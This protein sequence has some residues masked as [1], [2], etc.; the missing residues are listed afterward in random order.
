MSETTAIQRPRWFMF[1][2]RSILVRLS[3]LIFA[4]LMPVLALSALLTFLYADA[5]KRV[6]EAERAY[7]AQ[8]AVLIIERD[9]SQIVG[10]L[11]SAAVL[12]PRSDSNRAEFRRNITLL[13]QELGAPIVLID[14][15]GQLIEQT[16]PAPGV[17]PR[18]FDMPAFESLFAQGDAVFSDVI[19]DEQAPMVLVAVPVRR[20][21]R[22]AYA[23]GAKVSPQRLTSVLTE[24]GI[25][26]EWIAGIV[27]SKGIFIARSRAA[28]TFVGKPARPEVVA[29]A[30]SGLP[31]GVFRNVTLDGI[32]T[33]SSFRR[34]SLTGWTAIIAVPTHIVEAPLRR[35]LYYLSAAALG[36][37]A[38][39]LT[40]AFLLGSL[41]ARPAKKL[42]A[43]ALAL[44]R[45][46][47]LPWTSNG[48]REFNQ[49]GRTFNEAAQI[50]RERDAARSALDSTSG[51]LKAILES[52]PDLIYGKDREGR[53]ILA[54][55]ATLAAVGLPWEKVEGRN[56]AQWAHDNEET[57]AIMANDQQVIESGNRMQFEEAFTSAQGR[58]VYLSSKAPLRDA[59][60]AIVG[61]VGVSSDITDRK[62]AEEHREFIMRELSHRSKNLLTV[63]LAIAQQTGGTDSNVR[64]FIGSFSSR[65]RALATLHDLLI[66]MNWHGAPLKTLVENQLAPFIGDSSR[67]SI[68]GPS[69][70]VPPQLAQM[71]S[72]ALHELATNAAKYGALSSKHGCVAVTWDL[73]GAGQGR[74]FR[75]TWS[76][77]GGPPVE[78]PVRKGFGSLVLEK[79]VKRNSKATSQIEFRKEGLLWQFSTPADELQ[80]DR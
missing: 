69:V 57:R 60:G 38:F 10:A 68:S 31:S 28:N 54:N 32:S 29:A 62:A 55:P 27:D 59:S 34:S 19:G 52:A 79:L 36:I 18:P 30:T 80:A 37:L 75:M 70:R 43:T 9:I 20:D 33:E 15:S 66:T 74:V 16:S 65:L 61:L 44:A 41:I 53:L 26:S 23:L 77:A 63:V 12:S 6:I 71:I 67:L 64:S 51:L 14:R 50:M 40:L 7:V 21:G 56:E 3:V 48:I 78:P 13:S 35:A 2:E 76:E 73:F 5:E 39:A 45:G 8:N 4:I 17:S 49:I 1:Q 72:L 58:R 47:T 25:R 46:D 42:Q 11:R 22:I 24:A